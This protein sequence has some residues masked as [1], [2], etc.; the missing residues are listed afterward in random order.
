MRIEANEPDSLGNEAFGAYKYQRLLDRKLS[1]T[2]RETTF[3]LK[4]RM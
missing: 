3:H 1:E 4:M 2:L